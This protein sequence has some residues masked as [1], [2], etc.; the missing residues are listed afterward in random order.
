M[1][2]FGTAILEAAMRGLPIVASRV[3][4]I[5]ELIQDGVTG[6]LVPPC[7]PDALAGALVALLQDGAKAARLGQAA[8]AVAR[9]SFAPAVL[10][11]GMRAVYER[12]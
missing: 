3:G 1:E 10:I 11:E 12:L 7:Q 5:P 9:S 8:A 6:I 2:G 4:G